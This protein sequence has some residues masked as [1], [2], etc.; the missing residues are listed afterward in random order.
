[1]SRAI[2]P[3]P[4]PVQVAPAPLAAA[5]ALD[6]RHLV[7]WAPVRS[8]RD[9]FATELSSLLGKIEATQVCE[10]DGSGITCLESF[11]D[12]LSRA[13]D[14]PIRVAAFDS[15][16]GICEALRVHPSSHEPLGVKR[17]YILWHEAHVMLRA[18]PELFGRMVDALVGVAAEGEYI[19]DDRLLLQ[20]T[21]FLGSAALDVYSE[22]PRGQ[23]RSWFS[24]SPDDSGWGLVTGERS[25]RVLSWRIGPAF[26]AE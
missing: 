1:L 6:E 16:G 21:V 14:V 23:M 9:G 5:S 12:V 8:E 24:R 7:A 17:R 11:R 4:S 15:S 3:C 26:V 19:H 13:I 2:K 10:L 20:R 25:P 18:D 22:D